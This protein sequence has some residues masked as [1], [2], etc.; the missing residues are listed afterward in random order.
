MRASNIAIAAAVAFV[1][2]TAA[3]RA[4]PSVTPQAVGAM[5]DSIGPSGTSKA[6]SEAQW[7]QI[8]DGMRDGDPQWLGLAPRLRHGGNAAGNEGIR[9]SVSNALQR[10]PEAVLRVA[11][12]EL[13]IDQIC[14]DSDIEPAAD[15]VK[16]YYISTVPAVQAVKSPNLIAER[17]ACLRSLIKSRSREI[18]NAENSAR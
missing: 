7:R 4:E 8:L 11:G 14:M 15:A 10:N 2:C 13:P 1:S 12:P 9:I 17:D 6:L 5:L 18:A 16:A 3:L